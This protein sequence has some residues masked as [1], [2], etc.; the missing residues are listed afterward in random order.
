MNMT[1]SFTIGQIL[2]QHATVGAFATRIAEMPE[3]V[4]H[5]AIGRR[6][7]RQCKRNGKVTCRLDRRKYLIGRKVSD[8][9]MD[10]VNVERNKFHGDWN[11]V[12]KPKIKEAS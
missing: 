12:I 11:Y 9:E 4:G 2:P 6:A 1:P 10:R 3:R 7:I 5:P 8:E